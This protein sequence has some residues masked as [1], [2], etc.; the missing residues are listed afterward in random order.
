MTPTMV[1]TSMLDAIR[2]L[3]R[4]GPR[5]PRALFDLPE[6]QEQALKYLARR[7]NESGVSYA[8]IGGA[9]LAANGVVRATKDLDF[10]VDDAREP[11]VH[12]IFAGLGFETLKRHPDVS[13][14]LLARLRVD[15]LYA[16][17]SYTKAML[18]RARS[19]ALGDVEVRAVMAE[20][21]IGFKLQALKNNPDRPHDR[22]DILAL[23]RE[24]ADR[25]DMT[26]LREYAHVLG[27]EALLDELLHANR[28]R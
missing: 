19:A 16:R 8:L 26:L 21:L 17:R 13:N 25:L 7:F 28:S 20:D 15:V 6:S 14:Y 4:L 9:A 24:N 5:A 10:L 22:G 27:Q 18:R 1:D 12:S 11:D 2:R 3:L 23:M